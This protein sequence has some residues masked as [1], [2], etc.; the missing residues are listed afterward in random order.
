MS[1]LIIIEGRFVQCLLTMCLICALKFQ[2]GTFGMGL[3]EV[4]GES[5]LALL[6]LQQVGL[7]DGRK[8]R[9]K[10]S[11]FHEKHPR[12]RTALFTVFVMINS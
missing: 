1:E 5:L 8:S 12:H 11:S 6:Q 2:S 4:E 3:F 9:T 10:M 7:N